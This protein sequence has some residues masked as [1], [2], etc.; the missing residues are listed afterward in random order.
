M[1]AT[2]L[3]CLLLLASCGSVKK[4]TK[5]DFNQTTDIVSSTAEEKQVSIKTSSE[6][7]SV[8]KTTANVQMDSRT[9]T[10][11]VLETTWYDTSRTDS[12]GVAPVL[13]TEKQKSITHYGKHIAKDTEK[14]SRN[15]EK[16]Q[17][18]TII[19]DFAN[20]EETV[21][22][23]NKSQT[24]KDVSSTETKQLQYMSWVLPGLA[25]VI[26]AAVLAYWVFTKYRQRKIDKNAIF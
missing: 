20:K 3:L 18:S 6:Q 21:E 5:E 2:G 19:Q 4:V 26:L 17:S 13:K 16:Q 24:Q 11:S 7:S 25:L 15:G 12:T 23:T 22:S 8:T 1:K 10:L 14:G 9:E